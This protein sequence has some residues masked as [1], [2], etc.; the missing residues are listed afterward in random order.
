MHAGEDRG[1]QHQGPYQQADHDGHKDFG[2][3]QLRWL[4]VIG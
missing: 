3:D 1:Q 2:L 4:G